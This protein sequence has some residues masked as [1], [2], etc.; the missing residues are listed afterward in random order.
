MSVYSFIPKLNR[1]VKIFFHDKINQ[2]NRWWPFELELLGTKYIPFR[3]NTCQIPTKILLD[4]TF[5]S[6]ILFG[7]LRNDSKF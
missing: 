6:H 5:P 1:I 4:M 7:Q 2:I 3:A